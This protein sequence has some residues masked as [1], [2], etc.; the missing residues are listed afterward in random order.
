ML[1]GK[2]DRMKYFVKCEKI[3]KRWYLKVFYDFGFFMYGLNGS[4]VMWFY[5][6]IDL[7]KESFFLSI[8]LFFFRFWKI[9]C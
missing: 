3:D 4:C 9:V 5:G 7:N 6:V 8:E 1:L 2:V